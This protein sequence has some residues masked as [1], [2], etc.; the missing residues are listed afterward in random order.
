MDGKGMIRL[1]DKVRRILQVLRENG[2]EAYAVGGC[3]RDSILG[4]EPSDWDITTAAAP[5]QVKALFGHTVDTGIAHG[6][7]TVMIGKEGFEVTTYRVDGSYSDGRHPDS[8]TFTPDLKEDLCRRDFTINAMAYSEEDGLV[9]LFGGME[10]LSRR[11]VRCVGS[12]SERFHEDAL[13]MLRAVRFAAQLGFSL[14]E[15]AAAAIRAQA[16]DLRKVSAERIRVELEKLVTSPDPGM[17]KTAWETGITAVVLPWFDRMMDQ[18]QNGSH[19]IYSVGEHTLETMR[20]IR[21]DR[22]LRFT[23]LFH[24]MGKPDCAVRT[25][26]GIWHFRGHAAKSAVIAREITD[27]LR[28]DRA[29]ADKCVRL[30]AV[31]SLYPEA[32]PAGVRCGAA[33]TGPDLFGLFLE[34]KR[35]DIMGQNPAVQE[36]KLAWLD[37]VEALWQEIRERGDCLKVSELAISG[38]DLIRDGV[39]PGPGM[40]RLLEALLEEVLEDPSLNQADLLLERSRQLR[41]SGGL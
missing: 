36:K 7:V 22:L 4:R 39:K 14:D 10:D 5:Q 35:A 13:R 31:H 28:F 25:P 20:N 40:G 41:Q 12:A 21:P 24:D 1:P 15:E 29:T 33:Q 3:V 37:K 17:L 18:V 19:H 30:V 32:T 11:V 6:T 34:V 8:V 26:D 2:F 16:G 9:D 38:S 23:M 27:R